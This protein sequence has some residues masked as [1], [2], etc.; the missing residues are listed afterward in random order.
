MA[1]LDKVALEPK[2]G[3][4]WYE[5]SLSGDEIDWGVVTRCEYAR[6]IAMTFQILAART[7][8]PRN[9]ASEVSFDHMN[10]AGNLSARIAEAL[11]D[12]CTHK[13]MPGVALEAGLG[14]ILIKGIHKSVEA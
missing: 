6:R 7:A 11:K 10:G 9:E 8:T 2:A 13:A 3:G 1:S 4:R 12:R 14:H 5:K